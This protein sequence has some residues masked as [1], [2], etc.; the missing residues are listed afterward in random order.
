MDMSDK[1]VLV[2]GATSGIGFAAASQLASMGARVILVGRN[3]T[4]GD[5]A[6]KKILSSTP[7]AVLRFFRADLSYQQDIKILVEQLISSEPKLDILIN[8]AGAF[9]QTRQESKE[10]LEMTFA[11]NHMG[12]FVLTNGLLDMLET[13]VD[14]RIIN[15]ASNAHFGAALDFADL[16]MEKKYRGWKAYQRSK[17]A[18]ILFTNELARRLKPK[19]VSVNALHPGFVRTNFGN[20]NSF[21]FRWGM[22]VA[23]FLKA[24]SVEKGAETLVYLASDP[25]LDGVSGTYFA[26]CKKISSSTE[27]RENV[28]S[29]RL[30]RKSEELTLRPL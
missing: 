24:I 20:N 2:T 1:T 22:R 25:S 14:S 11:L 13:S 16:Q 9:F 6:K 21:V 26:N 10:G 19:K 3:E 18:N 30:W 17:L 23:M 27:A 4:K 28:A 12:Y 29:E 7:Q 8:N 15:V 5:L